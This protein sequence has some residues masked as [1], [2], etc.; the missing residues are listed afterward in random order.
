MPFTVSF[1]WLAVSIKKSTALAVLFLCFIS[2]LF[3][4]V[5]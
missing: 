3:F 1:P 4:R 2:I 5:P